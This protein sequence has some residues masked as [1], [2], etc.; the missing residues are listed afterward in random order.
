ML[1]ADFRYYKE[2][3]KGT[4][5]ENSFNSLILK[6]SKTIDQNINTRLSQQKIESLPKEAQ[7]QL[8]YTAC[9]LVDLLNKKE[10]NDNKN[11]NSITIDGV[12]KTFRTFSKDEIRAEQYEILKNLP[13]ELTRYL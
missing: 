1:Y 8:E 13:S 6:A 10:E 5:T 9:A 12:S 4:L 7:E 2:T 3:Y 11:V